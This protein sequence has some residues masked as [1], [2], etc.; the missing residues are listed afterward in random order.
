VRN[1]LGLA[2]FVIFLLSAIAMGQETGNSQEPANDLARRVLLHEVTAETQDHSHW[3][4]QSESEKSE[5]KVV[6][7]VVE[8]KYGDLKRHLLIDGRPLNA[9]QELEEDV[10]IQKLIHNPAVLRRSMKTD[11]EDSERSQK[12]LK[13]LPDALIF[14]YGERRGDLVELR[15]TSNPKFR[16]TTHEAQVFQAL[17]GSMW[18]NSKQS[19]LVE[20]RGHLNKEVKFGGGWL[21]H[22]NR[23]G[24][25]EV[26]QTEVAPG[27]WELSLL[28]VNMRGKC[29]F[30]KSINL[31]QKMNRTNF[32]QV[33]D[34]LTLSQAADLLRNQATERRSSIAKVSR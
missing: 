3:I 13:M 14:S 28:N 1:A 18:I 11:N 12:M 7:E 24:Q 27:Y 29:L 25:F 21:G 4:L 31:S 23:G 5:E 22:L 10:R 30:F 15:F 9:R 20:F 33:S 17:E 8:T 2:S 26:K 6:D 34:D 19:R 16:P 32:R